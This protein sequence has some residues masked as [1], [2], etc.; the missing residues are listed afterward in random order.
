MIYL[1]SKKPI[2]LCAH[3]FVSEVDFWKLVFA[4]KSKVNATQND[5]QLSHE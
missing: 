1:H 3:E 5:L 2:Q 4:L